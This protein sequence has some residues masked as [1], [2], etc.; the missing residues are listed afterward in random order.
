[1]SHRGPG[2]CFNFARISGVLNGRANLRLRPSPRGGG[3]LLDRID[4][5]ETSAAK[6]RLCVG[7]RG[8]G[9]ASELHG[10]EIVSISRGPCSK[11]RARLPFW[12]PPRRGGFVVRAEKLG[13]DFH[14]ASAVVY[15]SLG[16]MMRRGIVAFGPSWR[17][18]V[19]NSC[20]DLPF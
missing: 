19:L 5:G 8:A 9:F 4:G 3:F 6:R 18:G 16:R 13:R 20:V 2:N 7:A 10:R 12:S 1:M 11:G 14:R 15:V 17:S